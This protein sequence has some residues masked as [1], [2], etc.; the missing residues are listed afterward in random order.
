VKAVTRA[1]E[2]EVAR[3]VRL[4]EDGGRVVQETRGWDDGRGVTVPQRSKEEA[5]DYRY[6][7]EPDI[8]PLQIS[9]Q[10]VQ[11]VRAK[12]P[13]LPLAKKARF[14]DLYGLSEYDAA[15]LTTSRATADY[16]EEVLAAA[17]VREEDSRA[18]FAKETANWLN[19]EM[20]RLL[21]EKQQD[22]SSVRVRP[23]HL[24]SLVELF[25]KRELNNAT[26]KAVFEDMFRTGQDPQAII[27]ARGLTKVADK[28]SLGPIV[29]Q[30]IAANRMAVSDYLAGKEPAL[31]FLMGQVMKASRGQADPELTMKL[32]RERLEGLK[33]AR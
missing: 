33:T 14:R 27:K 7:P 10:W 26:A 4:I 17:N 3:Q 30:V 2:Y 5:H 29:E 6:F 15:L 21:N 20:A 25:R 19:G 13:E 8:P 23:A 32:L 11:E 31:R 9:R 16:F 22:V 24:A 28:S 18:A 12:L 1:L